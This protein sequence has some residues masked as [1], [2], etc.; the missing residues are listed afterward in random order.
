MKIWVVIFD[1]EYGTDHHAFRKY[2]DAYMSAVDFLQAWFTDDQYDGPNDIPG[3]Y[4]EYVCG[5]TVVI[6]ETEV[7]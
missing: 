6:A 3:D 5:D 2:E 4:T 7:M 1:H